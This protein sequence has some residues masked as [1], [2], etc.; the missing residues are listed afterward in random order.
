MARSLFVASECES[1][2]TGRASGAGAP[3]AAPL[4]V[5]PF[6]AR[7]PADAASRSGAKS[8]SPTVYANVRAVKVPFPSVYT[9]V[10]PALR[11]RVGVPPVVSTT[12]GLVNVPWM[13]MAV[14]IP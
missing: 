3:L 2:P 10:P 6:R 8:P 14:P 7:A 4:I 12:T 1:A 9:A 13:E 11:A 5:A